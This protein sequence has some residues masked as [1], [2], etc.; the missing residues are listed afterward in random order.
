MPL[1][2]PD[3]RLDQLGLDVDAHAAALRTAPR[4]GDAASREHES[5][6]EEGPQYH[7]THQWASIVMVGP[8]CGATPVSSRAI[9]ICCH[10]GAVV[11]AGVVGA[12]QTTGSTQVGGY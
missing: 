10:G 7:G 5:R 9:Q 4:V 3:P 6:H 12:G 8:I 1:D 2:Q 11:G